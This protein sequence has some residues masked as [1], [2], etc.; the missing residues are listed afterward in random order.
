[1]ISHLLL[2][3]IFAFAF[4]SLALAERRLKQLGNGVNVCLWFRGRNIPSPEDSPSYIDDEEMAHMKRI[5]IQHVRLCVH[6]QYIYSPE[7]PSK[8]IEPNLGLVEAAV[9][10]FID[11]GIAVVFDFHNEN[12][13]RLENDPVWRNGLVPFWRTLAGRLRRFDPEDLVLEVI[14][15]PVFKGH[16]Q[17]WL[18]FQPK[19]IAAIREGAPDHTIIATGTDWSNI[20]HM[21]RMQPLT[22][23]NLIYTFHCYDPHIFTHQGATWSEPFYPYIKGVPYPSSPEKL[24]PLVDAQTNPEAKEGL[25]RYGEQRWDAEKLRQHLQ[26]AV[27]WA[28]ANRVPIYCGE[29]GCY[30]PVTPPDARI[31]WFKDI[32]SVFNGFGIGWALWGYDEVFGLNRRKRDGVLTY[33]EGVSSLLFQNNKRTTH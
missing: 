26:S 22:D 7:E 31:R 3:L 1:M 27:D 5:G 16:E 32:S 29:F 6:P 12:Q 19:L 10:R 20:G 2:V 9:Q 24:K 25:R 8:P 23:P 28:S 13:Q 21:T 4:A 15:E 33:D 18:D 14:N 30:T 17:D 11:H